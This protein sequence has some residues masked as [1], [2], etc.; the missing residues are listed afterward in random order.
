LPVV[1]QLLA[2]RIS[3][4]SGVVAFFKYVNRNDDEDLESF[5]GFDGVK[6]S[7]S[8]AFLLTK[9]LLP[10]SSESCEDA[11]FREDQR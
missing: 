8:V 11:D 3:N 6:I 9:F 2:L 7:H 10:E 5:E 1:A 4:P